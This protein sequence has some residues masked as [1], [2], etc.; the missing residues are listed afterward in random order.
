MTRPE[1]TWLDRHRIGYLPWAWATWD[2]ATG[3]VLIAR[4]DG[5]PTAYAGVHEHLLAAASAVAGQRRGEDP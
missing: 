5:T 3:P 4:Y 1:T 2:C